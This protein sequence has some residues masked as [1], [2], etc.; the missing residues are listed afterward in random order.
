MCWFSLS[1]RRIK[2]LEK[3]Q[4]ASDILKEQQKGHIFCLSWKRAVEIHT[5]TRLWSAGL[6]G[7]VPV[8]RTGCSASSNTSLRGV[9]SSFLVFCTAQSHRTLHTTWE[10]WV[11]AVLPSFCCVPVF[12]PVWGSFLLFHVWC[13]VP[14]FMCAAVSPVSSCVSLGRHRS[15]CS[16]CLHFKNAK[17]GSSMLEQKCP[18]HSLSLTSSFSFKGIVWINE[19]LFIAGTKCSDM[20]ELSNCYYAS[21]KGSLF[22]DRNGNFMPL[23]W[24]HKYHFKPCP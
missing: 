21:L 24:N 12:L 13:A 11:T 17:K 20:P 5:S 8:L 19:R 7:K 2:F 16:W 4:P 1:Y 23:Q 6:W 9:W 3:Y 22:R 10:L 18:R 15:F 14:R